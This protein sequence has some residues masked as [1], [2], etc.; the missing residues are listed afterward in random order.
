MSRNDADPGGLVRALTDTAGQAVAPLGL[1]VDE[2]TVTPA[3]KRRVVRVSVDDDLSSLATGD[4]RS[5]VPGVSLDRVAE[6]TKAVSAA[7]DDSE[8]LGEA[9]YV[10]E[11][12][13]PG[14]GRPLTTD[15]QFRRN[16]GRLLEVTLTSG[17]SLTGR[18][19]AARPGEV[20]LTLPATK[21]EPEREDVIPL[22]DIDR[23]RVQVEFNR[24]DAADLTGDDDLDDTDLDDD[25]HSDTDQQED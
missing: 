20:T 6:A 17:G 1:T 18:I 7:F 2:L 22:A 12:S 11:V 14:V 13:S 16:V 25:A 15:R 19:A 9:P 21:T 5:V 23:A 8:A 3:G 4:E 24:A 10:L